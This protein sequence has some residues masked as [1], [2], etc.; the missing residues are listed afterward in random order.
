VKV[1]IFLKEYVILGNIDIELPL[2]LNTGMIGLEVKNV[3][4]INA[5]MIDNFDLIYINPN[6]IIGIAPL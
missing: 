5:D 3:N 6:E 4:I 2:R 1:K